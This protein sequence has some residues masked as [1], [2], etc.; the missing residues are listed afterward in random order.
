[1]PQEPA[2]A[3]HSV[4]IAASLDP[5]AAERIM[6][7][8]KEIMDHYGT[9]YVVNKDFPPH[10]SLLLTGVAAAAIPELEEIVHD[11]AKKHGT[12][13]TMATH[14]DLDA[15]GFLR[16]VCDAN[17]QLLNLHGELVS[18]FK[19][20]H[21][22]DPRFRPHDFGRWT[23]LKFEDGKVMRDLFKPHVSLGW[24]DPENGL[25]ARTL[26]ESILPVPFTIE[27][28][29]LDLVEIGP[30]NQIWRVITSAPLGKE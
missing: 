14:I 23:E 26:A 18:L 8:N 24:V 11:M 6:L 4:A 21:D 22:R 27:L 10:L 28:Q 13:T 19:V 16:T 17:E 2:K 25:G 9:S 1:M 29:T 15:T 7:V 12:L 30:A 20:I 5:D 3:D